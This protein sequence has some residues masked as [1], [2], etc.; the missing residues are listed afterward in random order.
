MYSFA[1]VYVIPCPKIICPVS[2]LKLLKGK[3]TQTEK[4]YAIEYTEMERELDEKEIRERLRKA[5]EKQYAGDPNK[6][7]IIE[8]LIESYFD[9]NSLHSMHFGT[10]FFAG[11]TMQ[12][13]RAHV[14]VRQFV[15]WVSKNEYE[16]RSNFA[17]FIKLLIK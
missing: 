14:P 15:R 4:R 2:E 12:D 6:E 16:E 8:S 11:M 17:N 7:K 9:K 13:G 3:K 10:S 5:F 1:W